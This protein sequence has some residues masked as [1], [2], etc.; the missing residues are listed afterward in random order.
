MKSGLGHAG[1]LAARCAAGLAGTALLALPFAAQAQESQIAEGE[2]GAGTVVYYPADFER[3]SPRNALDMLE[4]V[5]GFTVERENNARGL[6]QAS[7]N[8]LI[9]GKRVS[10]KSAGTSEQLGR[11]PASKVVRIEVSDGA[12][13]NIAG[14]SGRVANVITEA[15]GMSG[16]FEWRS[17]L[18]TGPA[19]FR[20]SQ[21]DISVSGSS[22]SVEYTIALVNDSFYGG[23]EGPNIVTDGAALVDPRINWNKSKMDRPTLS[24][25]FKIDLPGTTVANINLSGDRGIFDSDEN[26]YRSGTA[27]PAYE[28]ALHNKGRD[29]GYELGGD[30]EFRVGNGRLK[31]IALESFGHNEFTSQS[32]TS[33]DDGNPDTGSRFMRVSESGERIGRFEY[34]WPMWGADWQISGE[35]AFNRLDNVAQLYLLNSSGEFVEISFPAGTGG[36]REDRYEVLLNYSRPLTGNLALQLTV[37]GE[38]SEISQTGANALTRSFKR[39]KG[40]LGLA[41]NPKQGL[42]ISFKLSRRV[43][44]LNFG[45][46]LASVNLGDANT[47]AGNNQLRPPQSWEADLEISK[48]LGEWGSARVTLFAHKAK[49]F[50]TFIPIETTPGTIRESRGNIPSAHRYGLNLDTTIQ[51]EPIGFKGAK[52]DIKGTIEKSGLK[53][54]VTGED[55]EFDDRRSRQIELDFRHDIPNSD[56]VWGASFRAT[57]FN[58]YFRVFETGYDYNVDTFGALF[59]EHKDVFGLTVRL[60]AANLFRKEIVL[61][62]TVYDGP[63][64]SSPILFTEDRRR[65]V[66]NIVN[67]TVSGSF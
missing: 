47:N 20:W 56:W 15:G 23:S 14:L 16:R 1:R 21:G 44:Q 11:I 13:L 40:S 10:S 8:V 5:P 6:G 37:G 36:V 18:A 19:A 49:D 67:L 59:I 17:Q 9:N 26:E 51:L 57:R 25:N 33:I 65:E 30:I 63:R 58:P 64:G 34:R 2:A 54:P 28:E 50:V 24:G 53:D 38:S 42:D 43:G 35:A 7:G 22:G 31:L 55:R 32:V 39:P 4:N 29:Y 48:N 52:L 66:G 61:Q 3:F 46:F 60:R 12:S 62:R 45:D 27:L 41:W